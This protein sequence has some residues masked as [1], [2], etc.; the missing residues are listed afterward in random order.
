MNQHKLFPHKPAADQIEHAC[1]WIL[2]GIVYT[3]YPKKREAVIK[4]KK[5]IKLVNRLATS[6]PKIHIYCTVSC[7]DSPST[8]CNGRL[9]SFQWYDISHMQ[10]A[11]G[12][13]TN[14]VENNITSLY[15]WEEYY[16]LHNHC[17]ISLLPVLFT[18]Q[19]APIMVNLQM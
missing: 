2:G 14:K 6:L 18:D 10:Q 11:S 8:A 7:I 17:K 4:W 1:V 16:R 19:I 5:L 13:N 15:P 12:I 9:L 3:Q